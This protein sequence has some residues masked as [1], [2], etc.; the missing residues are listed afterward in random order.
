MFRGCCFY[1]ED[2]AQSL[3]FSGLGL[4]TYTKT[5]ASLFGTWAPFTPRRLESLRLCPR[6]QN[7]GK[8]RDVIAMPLLV[9]LP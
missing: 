9:V 1:Y 6:L 4:E 7:C 3:I 2:E 5:N 8:T